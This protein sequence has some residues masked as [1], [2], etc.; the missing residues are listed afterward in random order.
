[1]QVNTQNQKNILRRDI[2][3]RRSE[4]S[5]K[6]KELKS[7]KIFNRLLGLN[8][9]KNSKNICIYVSKSDEVDTICL[10]EHLISMGKAVYAPKSDKNSNKMTF[11][12]MHSL[13]DLKVGAFSVLEPSEKNEKYIYSDKNDICIVPALCFDRQ[14]YR[15]GYGKGYYD[16]FLKNFN[17]I[18]IGICFNEFIK[19]ALPIFNTD[20]AV[21][22]IISDDKKYCCKG[23]K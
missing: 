7:R 3:K 19:E 2:L 12:R 16:R 15:L 11:F 21:D 1:M 13:T 4:L 6:E 17:G 22:M 8:E 14:G 9:I 23:G 20:I 18:K 5:N 10:I